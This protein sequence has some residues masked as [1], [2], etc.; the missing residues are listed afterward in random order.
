LFWYQSE[1]QPSWPLSFLQTAPELAGLLGGLFP[2]SLVGTAV[3][4]LFIAVGTPWVNRA[5]NPVILAH[6]AG[7]GATGYAC[8]IIGSLNPS[9]AAWILALATYAIA[10][11][12]LAGLLLGLTNLTPLRRLLRRSH[13]DKRVQWP[14]QRRKKPADPVQP[15]ANLPVEPAEE[16]A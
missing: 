8:Y 1:R 14:R 11:S 2:G 10:A 13:Q 9:A 3:A 6:A 12:L 7:V 16:S 15:A 4:R 5:I